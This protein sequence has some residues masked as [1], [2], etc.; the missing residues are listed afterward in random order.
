MIKVRV[1]GGW[2]EFQAFMEDYIRK[3]A[4]K[5]K[6][7]DDYESSNEVRARLREKRIQNGNSASPPISTP[8]PDEET[9]NWGQV[10]LETASLRTKVVS[11]VE[12]PP[13]KSP[14]QGQRSSIDS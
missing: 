7:L 13:P 2:H 3:Y 11:V 14:V 9:E 5:G 1:G 4:P 12:R 6:T 8:P 10:E